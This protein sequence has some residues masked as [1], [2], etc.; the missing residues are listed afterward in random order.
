M[1][2]L[3]RLLL[4]LFSIFYVSSV[5][6]QPSPDLIEGAKKE[7]KL[8]FYTVLLV[9]ENRA[10][11]AG[12]EKKY[13]FIKTEQFRL[14]A[15][16]MRTKIIT[17]FRAGRHVF[18]VTS[19]NVIDVGLLLRQGVLAPY[20]ALARDGIRDGLKDEEGYW[21][22]L[23]VRKYVLTYNPRLIA[24]ADLPKDWWDLLHPKWKGKIG[25]DQEETEWYAGLASYWGADKARKFMKG[26]LAQ[27]FG[28]RRGHGIIAQLTSA[29]E[30]LL[31]IGYA[32]QI[33]QMK[34]AG[35]PL[36]WI[37]TTD[38][39]VTSP[40]V[41]S[42]SSRAAH[43]YSAR[44]FTEYVLSREGQLLI[45]SFPRVVAHKQ[46]PPPSPKLDLDRLKVFY[47]SPELADRYEEFQ[48]EYNEIFGR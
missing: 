4:G 36:D 28:M 21:T 9:P 1:Q 16:K 14:G 29:G 18:D 10:L 35:A 37:E 20:K 25:M 15:E 13:P 12:F 31:S 41:V 47:I 19:M 11:L 45:Q 44:L 42:I 27:D 22:G 26:L 33:E 3:L 38:P 39:V 7:G 46:V 34:S 5:F 6:A 8:V 43:P 30:F 23:Y 2:A 48:R 24:S 40:S 32:H 17:E